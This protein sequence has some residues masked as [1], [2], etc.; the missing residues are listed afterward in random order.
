M[1]LSKAL[2]PRSRGETSPNA[3]S[4]RPPGEQRYV[5]A[6]MDFFS[7][8]HVGGSGGSGISPIDS[9]KQPPDNYMGL[10]ARQRRIKYPDG[11]TTTETDLM[12]AREFVV[13]HE[14]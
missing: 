9:L 7:P 11:G 8:P 2:S 12:A 4:W 14:T 5:R 3:G 1:L 10:S 13:H 6:N